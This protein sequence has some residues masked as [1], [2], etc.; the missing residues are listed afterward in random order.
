MGAYP[1][2]YD[3][4]HSQSHRTS[5]TRYRAIMVMEGPNI[6][7]G[8]VHTLHYVCKYNKFV[9][10]HKNLDFTHKNILNFHVHWRYISN[11]TRLMTLQV[12]FVP[13]SEYGCTWAWHGGRSWIAG[14][15]PWRRWHTIA[16]GRGWGS[17]CTWDPRTRLKHVHNS[18]YYDNDYHTCILYM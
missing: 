6:V 11:T 4:Y 8:I 3:K 5:F 13:I 10:F 1:G 16:R 7:V 15:S 17:T 18:N 14:G 9:N 12:H 2:Y